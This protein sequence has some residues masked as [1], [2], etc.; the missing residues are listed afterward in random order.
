MEKQKRWQLYLILAVLA[1]TVINILPT[2]FYYSKPLKDPINE[3]RAEQVAM[4]IIDRVDSLEENSKEWLKA[5]GKVL[6]ANPES[7]KLRDGDPGIFEVVFKSSEEAERFK[8]FLPQ[9]GALIPF[10]PAQLGLF[11]ATDVNEKTVLV[12]RQIGVHLDPNEASNLFHF[13][14]K[15][16]NGKISDAYRQ[17]IYER[18]SHLG[19]I[20]AGPS[21]AA[22]Q[23]AEIN[24]NPKAA[25]HDD[26]VINLAKEIVEINQSLGED[27]PITKRYYAS[28]LQA[29]N[30][31]ADTVS[32]FQK[33][34]ESVK[35]RLDSQRKPLLSEQIKLEEKGLMLPSEREQDLAYLNGQ[36]RIVD[37]ANT[38]IQKHMQDFK[39]GVPPYNKNQMVE[40]LEVSAQKQPANDPVQVVD[41]A[42]RN[43]LFQALSI[44]WD[45]NVIILKLYPDIAKSLVAKTS[46]EAGASLKEKLNQLIIADVTRISY[47][48]DETFT[49]ED[50]SFGVRLTALTDPHSFLTLDLSYLSQKISEQLK[51]QLSLTWNPE[52]SDLKRDVYPVMSY[53]EYEQL[54]PEQQRLGLVI[55]APSLSKEEPPL[56][57]KKDTIYII[58]RGLGAIMQKYQETPTGPGAKELQSDLN[59][60]TQYLQMKGFIGYSGNS[61]G[62]AAEYVNDYIFALDDYYSMLL[63][64]TR[65]E[66]RVKGTKQASVLDFTDVEQR[67]IALN[68]IE[69]RKHEDLLKWRDEYQ[70]AQVDINTARRYEV[71]PPVKNVYWDNFKLSFKKYFRGDQRK[72]LKWGLDLS[73]GKTVRI[74]L[75]DHSGNIVTN[76]DDL[77]Q[78][79]NELYTRINKMGV[80]ERTI[81]TEGNYIVLDF[82]SSQAMSASELIQGSAMYFHI[83]N[84]KFTPNNVELRD[85][86]NR[87]L[88]NVWNEAVVTNRKDVVSVNE[89]AWK[90]LGGDD[91]TGQ[92][93]PRSDLAKTL[94]QNGLRF[95]APNDKTPAGHDF[96]DALSKVA[97]IRGA[98]TAEWDGQAHPL[99]VVFR[100]YALEGRNL[101]NVQIGYDPAEGNLLSF[102]VKRSYD[103]GQGSP[104]DDFFTWTSQ[105]AEDK[106]AGTPKETYSLGRGWR[107]AVILNDT[108]ITKPTLRAALRDG[109]TISGRFSHREIAQ[110]AADLKAG[111][112][113][114]TPYI[115]SEENVSPELGRTER[116]R[117]I[118]A[119]LVSLAIVGLVMISYYRFAG[120]VAFCAVL[121][122]LL[123]MWGVLVNVDAVMTLPGIA[124]VV[125]AIA[126]AVDANVLVFERVREEFAISGRIGAA[127]QAGYKKAY[128]AI[129]DSNIVTIMA[130]LILIQFD[131][132]PVKGFAVTLIIGLVS[133]LFTA[134]FMTRYFFAGWVQNPKHKT[135]DM[136]HLI[137]GTK[138]DF[139]GNWPR[140]MM[141]SGILLLAGSFF[142]VEQRHTL[143]GTD[144]TGGYSLTAQVQEK[145]NHPNYRQEAIDALLAAGASLND[146]QI[147]ELT[148]PNHLRIQLGMGMEEKG[149]PFYQMPEK[150]TGDV[151]YD[152]ENNPRITWVVNAL[153]KGG[154]S[155]PASDLQELQKNWTVMSG[156]LSET[157]RNNAIIALGLALLS[158]LI[159][160]TLRF[161]FKFAVG[162]VAGLVHDVLI[163]L[164]VLA[165]FHRM[166]FP[167]QIDL[168]VIGAIMTII[169]YSLNDTIIVFDR[170]R[171]DIRI[172]R[173]MSFYDLVNHALNIT[174]SRTMMTSGITLLVL[175]SLVFLG[176]WSIFAFALCMT[177]GV[178]FGTLS[179]L[180]VAS[181]IMMYLHNR[182][183]KQLEKAHS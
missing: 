152:Y 38:I 60:L 101:T 135:L 86:V 126:L 163:T 124:G 159:Y 98:D 94:Y 4:Q 35:Q 155:V 182:E 127:L 100:N 85:S 110:L 164:G 90:H 160:I 63:N 67:I 81:R 183:V 11:P 12:S 65:E 157:M 178:V 173:R 30:Q 162:A 144:F 47:L 176:G 8:H 119:S 133:S 175:L 45:N 120:L 83:V 41:L 121:V 116:T 130:C 55:Y 115:L 174:L 33:S 140:V 156:Q 150:T 147:R 169:G 7:I 66:F 170:I 75:R 9:A 48:A 46:S 37:T 181:P 114:F 5:F 105:F 122:N 44:D 39:A 61:F 27:N 64:A 52:Y 168:Q 128:S 28:F 78:A 97:I 129:I 113:S 3:K 57:F 91:I 177:I 106:I 15:E 54:K 92:T 17:L 142:F 43:P 36:Y 56:G 26:E 89:I 103:D 137:H 32:L 179:S 180:F 132:G 93:H 166:G 58:A 59:T 6:K 148:K 99:L 96:N 131:S 74:G 153:E 112:L 172:H 19:L 29:E 161:E 76:P 84:E 68:S 77:K 107:M 62:T 138:F 149:H 22:L 146:V 108:V 82:P 165:L 73:G 2:V 154:L 31:S 16:S 53:A 21:R 95:A 136:M 42:G 50:D 24:K 20:V 104:R 117:G 151:T 70:S 123:I 139:L 79:V 51:D 10:T 71:P 88:Q 40:A 23:L 171:E 69:D 34:L 118:V 80:S 18:A 167:V 145:P 134:L 158:I 25:E 13:I 143:F 102:S 1:W 125:L 49:P 111:S 87:F 141:I 72:I 14:P 109:G